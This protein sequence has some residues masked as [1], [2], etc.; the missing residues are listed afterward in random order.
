MRGRPPSLL[1]EKKSDSKRRDCGTKLPV[2]ARESDFLTGDGKL[3]YLC[4]PSSKKEMKRTWERS[5]GDWA[6][7]MPGVRCSFSPLPN[8][9]RNLFI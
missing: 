8:A 5:R 2:L 3:Y 9:G 7:S 6:K 1:Q 4:V